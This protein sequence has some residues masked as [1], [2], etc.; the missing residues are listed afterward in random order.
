MFRY[1]T[2]TL[3][4]V[5]LVVALFSAALANPSHL[6]RQVTVTVTVVVL[7]S[8]TLLAALNSSSRKPFALG[9]AIVGWVYFVLT[10]ASHFGNVD[11]YLLTDRVVEWSGK[12]L[13]FDSLGDVKSTL[14][15][16]DSAL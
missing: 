2:L 1:S 14:S 5:V 8:F 12:A 3:L 10:F 11:S 6:W 15:P 9:F 13:H 4:V 16:P 7:V